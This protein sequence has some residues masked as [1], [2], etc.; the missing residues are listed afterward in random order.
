MNVCVCVCMNV[1]RSHLSG[2]VYVCVFVCVYTCVCVNARARKRV[3][4][5][6]AQPVELMYI[7][8]CARAVVYI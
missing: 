4:V 8:V 3:H 2:T 6:Q 7:C 5:R 1:V